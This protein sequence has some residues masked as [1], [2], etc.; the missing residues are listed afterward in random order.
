MENTLHSLL[1]SVRVRGLAESG[2]QVTCW[3][4]EKDVYDPQDVVY[5]DL[6]AKKTWEAVYS[7][8][9][10]DGKF[11]FKMFVMLLFHVREVPWLNV[12]PLA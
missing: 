7:A 10:V 1:Y 9:C 8:V 5:K 2:N 11:S 12:V 3:L 6:N 4:S